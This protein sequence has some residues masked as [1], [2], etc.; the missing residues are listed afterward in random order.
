MVS[1]EN[2]FGYKG[3]VVVMEQMIVSEKIQAFLRGD[4]GEFAAKIIEEEACRDG[5][6]TL[7]QQG[8]ILA[9]AGE[10]TIDEVNRVI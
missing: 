2:P 4:K 8:V 1:N 9:L 5:M 3:R 7:L 6:L 10:T